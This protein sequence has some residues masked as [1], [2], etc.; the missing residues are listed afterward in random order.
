MTGD[1]HIGGDGLARGYHKRPELTAERF[2]RDPLSAE[3]KAF[4]FYDQ[5]LP[6]ISDPE[7]RALFIELRDEETEHQR[8]LRE[9]I[10]ALPPGADIEWEE[11]QDE[12]PAL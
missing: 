11:D 12:Y 8:M 1:I 5:A 9:A 2:V 10:A 7:I 4:D 6:H 3:Q